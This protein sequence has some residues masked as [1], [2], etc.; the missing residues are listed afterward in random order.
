MS[1]TWKEIW[2]ISKDRYEKIGAIHQAKH[3]AMEKNSDDIRTYDVT[4]KIIGEDHS[5]YRVEVTFTELTDT[6][7]EAVEISCD[8]CQYFLEKSTEK[9]HMGDDEMACINPI[10]AIR[11]QVLEETGE[12]TWAFGFG[13][14]NEAKWPTL[15]LEKKR[16]F[17]PFILKLAGGPGDAVH[18]EKK[19]V[20]TDCKNCINHNTCT[21]EAE[22]KKACDCDDYMEMP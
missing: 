21:W 12:R 6:E 7:N 19:P 22:G 17:C 5:E 11:E 14:R 18:H 9:A 1:C 4:A 3:L 8:S 16:M 13:D 20:S 15:M 2:H 10:V